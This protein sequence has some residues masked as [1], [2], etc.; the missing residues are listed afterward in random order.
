MT[1]HME[2]GD[3]PDYVTERYRYEHKGR[4]GDSWLPVWLIITVA[5]L[6]LLAKGLGANQDGT[7]W[8]WDGSLDLTDTVLYNKPNEAS[9]L[10]IFDLPPAPPYYLQLE[11]LA[12]VSTF[13]VSMVGGDVGA[14]VDAA[15]FDL[16]VFGYFPLLP[17]G[18]YTLDVNELVLSLPPQQKTVGF[19]L[20]GWGETWAMDSECGIVPQIVPEPSALGTLGVFLG[21]LA[22]IRRRR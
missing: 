1:R 16:P 8:Q 22:G 4:W 14:T 13:G 17:Y 20:V 2:Q 21:V 7:L 15:D 10:M 3:P 19:R 6:L 5:L 9:S 18:P 11:S 12:G